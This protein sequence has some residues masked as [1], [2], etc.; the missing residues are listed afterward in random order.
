MTLAS[1]FTWK[2]NDAGIHASCSPSTR[3]ASVLTSALWVALAGSSA[4]QRRTASL[5]AWLNDCNINIGKP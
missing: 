5:L 3:L 2:F 1:L 4:T